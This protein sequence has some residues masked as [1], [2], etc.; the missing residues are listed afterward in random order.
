[1]SLVPGKFR[2]VV[3]GWELTTNSY[4]ND[5]NQL[6]VTVQTDGEIVPGY[7]DWQPLEESQKQTAK[8]RYKFH[9][10]EEVLKTAESLEKSFPGLALASVED[11]EVIV[12]KSA[13]AVFSEF[14]DKEKGE[15]HVFLQYLNSIDS[16]AKGSYKPAVESITRI[17][18]LLGG[19][20]I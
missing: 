6:V 13:V 4:K 14:T 3:T 1:M 9:T 11:V 18:N 7:E 20:R 16:R 15:T 19:R 17:D 12:G 8:K 10:D 5:E 2:V